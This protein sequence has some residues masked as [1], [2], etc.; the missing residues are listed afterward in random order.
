M[1]ILEIIIFL[2]TKAALQTLHKVLEG[3]ELDNVC[4]VIIL[5]LSSKLF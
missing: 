1:C 5:A 2:E 4:K 3:M